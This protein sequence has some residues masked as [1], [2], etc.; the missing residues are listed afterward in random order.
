MLVHEW[1]DHLHEFSKGLHRKRDLVVRVRLAAAR[2]GDVARLEEIPQDLA[3]PAIHG[4]EAN[5]ETK[6][7]RLLGT[8]KGSFRGNEAA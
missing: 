6:A 4:S 3:H 7:P 8:T 2:G 1:N 5:G